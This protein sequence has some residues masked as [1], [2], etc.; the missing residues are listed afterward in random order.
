MK[1]YTYKIENGQRKGLIHTQRGDIHTP[2]FMP[3]TTFG[4]KY[5]LDKLV[6]PYLKRLSQCIMVSYYYA[7]FMEERP[8]MP[9]FIDSGGFASIFE[10]AT[11]VENKKCAS[12]K[13]NEEEIHPLKVLEFQEENAD[14]AAT[15]DF[16]ISPKMDLAE[17]KRRQKLTIKNALYALEQKRSNDLIL[18]ASLQ[19]WDKKSARECAREYAQAGFDGI[20]I[21]GLVP[22][23]KDEDYVKRI[24]SVVKEEALDLAVHV[25]GIGKPELIL[26][27]KKMSVDSFDSS[28][29]IK[30]TISKN[31][32]NSQFMKL[33]SAIKN[34]EL[35][36]SQ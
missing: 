23:V 10:G 16:I 19:C 35:L 14:L 28:S 21:G 27:L 24:V 20:A 33:S 31:A 11:I 30:S 34:L 8:N 6:R 13:T 32:N 7:Q 36:A 9:M 29:Y 25:F 22:R 4:D 1:K 26:K 18:F 3:V 12:I 5:P 17:A 15:L 2:T